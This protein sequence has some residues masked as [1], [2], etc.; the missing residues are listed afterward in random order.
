MRCGCALDETCVWLLARVLHQT[1]SGPAALSLPPTTFVEGVAAFLLPVCPD[2]L[3]VVLQLKQHP[4]SAR[5]YGVVQRGCLTCPEHAPAAASAAAPPPPPAVC[6]GARCQGIGL[7]TAR[8]NQV[9]CTAPDL[10]V[11][12][13]LHGSAVGTAPLCHFHSH[14]RTCTVLIP[15]S[16]ANMFVVSVPPHCPAFLSARAPFVGCVFVRVLP[17]QLD[18]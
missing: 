12:W 7:T 9:G 2:A 18:H 11:A 15:S 6:A 4:V 8:Q 13:A 10:F 14:C 1:E 5:W 16:L 3:L 17:P